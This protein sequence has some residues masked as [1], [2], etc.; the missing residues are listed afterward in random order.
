MFILIPAVLPPF[1]AGLTVRAAAQRMND[2]AGRQTWLAGQ[3]GRSDLTAE[4]RAT[5]QGQMT[6]HKNMEEGTKTLF[7][8][9]NGY[10]KN[11]WEAVRQMF[12]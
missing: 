11:M 5:Y 9:S 6:D 12:S 10:V 7:Q 8:I 3:L 1:N 2:I 4:Q